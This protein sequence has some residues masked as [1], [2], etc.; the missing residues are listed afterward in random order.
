MKRRKSKNTHVSSGRPSIEWKKVAINIL[1][2]ASILSCIAYLGALGRNLIKVRIDQE[3]L[4]DRAK[5]RYLIDTKGLEKTVVVLE[6]SDGDISQVWQVIYDAETADMI[7]YY[8]PRWVYSPDYSRI[9]DQYI[10][11]SDY[12]YA[13]FLFEEGRE[14]E[15]SLWQLINLTGIPADSYIWFGD[16]YSNM[17][18]IELEGDVT[19]LERVMNPFSPSEI[20]TKSSLLVDLSGEV[21]T[22][23]D[24]FALYRRANRILS[25]YSAGYANEINLTDEYAT[26]DAISQDGDLIKVVNQAEVDRELDKLM[27][28]VRNRDLE[29]EQVKVEVFNGSTVSGAASR[30]ARRIKNAGLKVVRYDNAPTRYKK[31]L[32]YVSDLDRFDDS[33]ELAAELMAVEVEITTEIPDFMTT[34]DIVIIL[35]QDLE[36]EMTWKK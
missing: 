32:I 13:G 2:T 34:G 25:V 22:N 27:Y 16:E 6:D 23:L 26:I 18:G 4:S 21:S 24:K 3:S 1:I 30:Y 9:F 28:I 12:K 31:T 5:D 19:D 35:G 20:L 17:A 15:Y 36:G 29:K 10:A 14:V 8:I 11:V 7:V 33:L